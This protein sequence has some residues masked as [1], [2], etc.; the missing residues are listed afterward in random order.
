M[1]WGESRIVV[2]LSRDAIKSSP[3]YDP[4]RPFAAEE[5]VRLH[6]YYKAS[7]KS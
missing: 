1:V 5:A 3:E 2:D 7:K 4:K 6:N